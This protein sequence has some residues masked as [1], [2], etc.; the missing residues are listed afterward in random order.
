MTGSNGFLGRYVCLELQKQNIDYYGWSSKYDGDLRFLETIYDK[1]NTK[2][3]DGV[4]HII[5]LAARCGGL[6]ANLATPYDFINDNLLMGLNIIELA[7]TTKA[8]LIFISS[9]CAYPEIPKTIPFIESE[10]FDSIPEKSNLPYG[11]SKRTLM[12]VLE[13]AHTQYGLESVTLNL[14]NTYGKNADSNLKTSHVIPAIVSKVGRAKEDNTNVTLLGNG[15]ATRDFLH[16]S[17]AAKAIVKAL[18]CVGFYPHGLNIGTGTE[19]SIREITEIICK[20]MDFPISRIKWDKSDMN[21]QRRRVLNCELAKK[22]LNWQSEINIE[23]GLL[24]LL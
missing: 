14:A 1:I 13:A 19:K 16:G 18:F 7:M 17:C 10:I 11:I 2:D 4:T 12:T 23:N 15:Q 21:G 3:L 20:Y 22:I 6:P 24:E 8:K 9:I 5:H